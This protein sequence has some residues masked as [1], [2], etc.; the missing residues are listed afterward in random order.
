MAVDSFVDKIV[1]SRCTGDKQ[2]MDALVRQK[3]GGKGLIGVT[4]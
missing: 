1:H 3:S 2:A 4:I